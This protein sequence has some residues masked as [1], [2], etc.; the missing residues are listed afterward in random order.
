MVPTVA[1][2]ARAVLDNH[3]R[4]ARRA[5]RAYHAARSITD[6]HDGAMSHGVAFAA[7]PT[8]DR[9]TTSTGRG[10]VADA[11]R[12]VDPV[13]ARSVEHET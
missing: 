4:A 13:G 5:R 9:S 2:A 8:G 1:G 12:A 6:R 10:I 3:D 11:L 7:G